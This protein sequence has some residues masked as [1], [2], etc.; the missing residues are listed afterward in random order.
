MEEVRTV[1]R[2]WGSSIAVVIPNNVVKRRKIRENEEIVIEIKRKPIAGEIF[3]L[4]PRKSKRGAQE[5]KNEM[6]AGW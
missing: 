3:G 5:I 4:F 2:K 6:R 1:A